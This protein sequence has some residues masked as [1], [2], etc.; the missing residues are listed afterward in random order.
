MTNHL[1]TRRQKIRA[2]VRS[3]QFAFSACL[4]SIVLAACVQNTYAP[5]APVQAVRVIVTF[6]QSVSFDNSA[7][8]LELQSQA[9]ARFG[10]IGPVSGLTHVYSVQPLQDEPVAQVLQRLR[11]LPVMRSVELDQKMKIQ[12]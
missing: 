10:H 11:S 2:G 1:P 12:Q 9:H 4:A 6:N 5:V 8:L 7:F 3:M